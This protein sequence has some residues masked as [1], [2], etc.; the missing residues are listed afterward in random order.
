MASSIGG[1]VPIS[2]YTSIDRDRYRKTAIV[3]LLPT[4]NTS[5]C[6]HVHIKSIK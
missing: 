5:E 6:A 1:E 2:T 3:R 4:V